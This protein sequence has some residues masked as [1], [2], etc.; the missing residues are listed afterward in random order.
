MVLAAKVAHLG[1]VGHPEA[2]EPDGR[3]HRS[4]SDRMLTRFPGVE[5]AIEVVDLVDAGRLERFDRPATAAARRAG[6][7]VDDIRL[8]RIERG[9]LRA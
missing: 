2:S 4:V 1:I 5:A 9:D 7:A 3:G 6:G 8:G